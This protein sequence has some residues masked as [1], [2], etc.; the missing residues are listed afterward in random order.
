MALAGDL[1]GAVGVGGALHVSVSPDSINVFLGAG[2]GGGGEVGVTVGP[3][4]EHNTS[5]IFGIRTFATY[6]AGGGFGG[7]TTITAGSNGV[8]VSG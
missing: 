8:S 6:G 3:A 2:V 1:A 7:S 4:F 5:S